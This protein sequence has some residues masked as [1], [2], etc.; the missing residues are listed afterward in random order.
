MSALAFFNSM[1]ATLLWVFG[2][3]GMGAGLMSLIPIWYAAC[4][5]VVI[6]RYLAGWKNQHLT[7]ADRKARAAWGKA[8]ATVG[9]VGA[10]KLT[11][12]ENEAKRRANGAGSGAPAGG[13][14]FS[15]EL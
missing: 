8:A 3:Y 6:F 7:H 13:R 4:R 5:A 2:R 9:A 1:T 12:G 14:Q 15:G 10:L 11:G